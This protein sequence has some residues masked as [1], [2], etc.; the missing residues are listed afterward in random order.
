M[1]K[2]K[3]RIYKIFISSTSDLKEFRDE[4]KKCIYEKG[5]IPIEEDT[6]PLASISPDDL[7]KRYIRISDI[8]IVLAGDKYGSISN[9]E[10]SYVE[11]EY[12]SAIENNIPVVGLI[13]K[14]IKKLGMPHDLQVK[15]INEKLQYK[16]TCKPFHDKST[17]TREVYRLMDNIDDN[18]NKNSGLIPYSHHLSRINDLE[19]QILRVKKEADQVRLNWNKTECFIT[20]KGVIMEKKKQIVS[21]SEKLLERVKW[22]NQDWETHPVLLEFIESKMDKI[23]NDLKYL[24]RSEG[25]SPVNI[26]ELIIWIEKLFSPSLKSLRATSIESKKAPFQQFN[27]YWVHPEISPL[28][29]EMNSQFLDKGGRINRIFFCDS[30]I[31][32][33]KEE[34]FSEVVVP[35]VNEGIQV[36]ISEIDE[37]KI[38]EYQDFGIYQH[39]IGD[40]DAG[41][42]VL[43]APR[44]Q[45]KNESF[46][47]KIISEPK[48]VNDYISTYD[49]Y[50]AKNEVVKVVNGLSSLNNKYY[51]EIYEKG[52][53]NDIFCN[54]VI[55]RN[56][57]RLDSKEK[58]LDNSGFVR[59]YEDEYAKAISSHLRKDEFSNS[60][61][62]LYFGDTSD[63][64]GGVIRNLQN[65]GFDI[66]GFICD[67]TLNLKNI[68]FNS[69]YFSSDWTDV[70]GFLHIIKEK[71]KNNPLV[72]FDIDQTLWAPKGLHEK[73]LIDA[74]ME[75]IT[76]LIDIYIDEDHGD[77]NE[78]VKNKAKQIYKTIS[79]PSYHELTKDNEDYKAAITI[80]LALGFYKRGIREDR[81]IKA[82]DMYLPDILKEY[83]DDGI[84]EFLKDVHSE[85]L[86]P[87]KTEPYAKKNGIQIVN[88]VYDIKDLSYNIIRNVP[89]PFTKFRASE[90]RETFSRASNSG[91]DIDKKITLNKTMWDVASFF[92]LNGANLIALSDRPDEATYDKKNSLLDTPMTIRGMSIE[93]EIKE[94]LN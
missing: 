60:S 35:Q 73:P 20:F 43:F 49:S 92:K 93:N 7:I 77:F 78:F 41:N 30:L 70:L 15:F 58:L 79:A 90:F 72:I 8:V 27:A 10:I 82:E 34:W 6:L 17:L 80:F 38:D 39:K 56:M 42:Y 89:A 75:A 19:N 44:Q 55:L 11:L 64:D 37:S 81:L 51:D 32:S 86:F 62:Y 65:R 24:I 13:Y 91:L 61:C 71:I 5:H 2:D 9:D 3:V 83:F 74:R 4:A 14:D 40:S 67:P 88:L 53:L 26:D 68:W 85:C 1:I 28:F 12:D 52:K 25:Y 76:E 59:K 36:K 31:K 94:I 48:K 87:P 54:R 21:K 33:V 22:I 66:S 16:R 84:V 18:V 45:N 23:E 69:V 50:W 47:T 29:K 46:G 63:N 57:V